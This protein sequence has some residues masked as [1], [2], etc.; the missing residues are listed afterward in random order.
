[1]KL[2][3][4]KVK[5]DPGAFCAYPFGAYESFWAFPQSESTPGVKRGFN[6]VTT[7]ARTGLTLAA[8]SAPLGDPALDAEGRC[9]L[10]DHGGFVLINVYVHSTGGA[11]D[12]G[13][14]QDKCARKLAFLRALRCKM[15]ALRAAGRRVVLCGD[16]NIAARGA[17]V[18][19]RQSLL[20]VSALQ[21]GR[22]A[23]GEAVAAP[24]VAPA[25]VGGAPVD[26]TAA[27]RI[28]QA[29][30]ALHGLLGAAGCEALATAL[31]T[32]GARGIVGA[33]SVQ[34][35]V[36]AFLDGN[37]LPEDEDEGEGEGEGEGGDEGGGAAADG[38]AA[39]VP[40]AASSGASAS[41]AGSGAG[42]SGAASA[43]ADAPA[44]GVPA[45]GGGGA[46]GSAA[47]AERL[48]SARD[49]LRALAHYC[50]VSPSAKDC[51]AWLEALRTE[52][53]MVDTFAALRPHAVA[54]FTCWHQCARRPNPTPAR[55]SRRP[56]LLLR[57]S[58]VVSAAP[59][60]R[61]SVPALAG[62]PTCATATTAAASTPCGS[63]PP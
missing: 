13:A 60:R 11:A 53:G 38:A 15:D 24:P 33:A 30:A 62:T 32:G 48:S 28:A 26:A 45:S 46:V 50:G 4:Q 63:T 51:V 21:L 27:E 25:G 41:T 10:T 52:D 8:D 35:K 7:Y 55:A 34:K 56:P 29:L 16:L 3:R 37:A 49:A 58:S 40:S 43:A 14:Y 12:D 20:P 36:E 61:A 57:Q 31:P 18:P 17:D 42:G 19:W 6:G 5:D 23:R 47:L 1:M 59:E 9:L 54:R 22:G 39:D 2:T 44:A